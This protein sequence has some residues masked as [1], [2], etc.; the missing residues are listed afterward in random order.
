MTFFSLT[1]EE[2]AKRIE[3]TRAIVHELKTPITPVLAA[4]ELL[5]EEIKEAPL[6]G[7]VESIDRSASNLNR[8]I[9][10]LLDLARGELNMLRIYP[11]PI[12]PATLLQEI[13]NET[14]PMAV[15]NRQSF[16]LDMSQSLPSIQADRDRVR[17]VILN[18]LNNAFKLTPAGGQVT[19]SARQDDSNL[20]IAV[21]DTGPGM[22]VEEQER[23]FN[24]YYR[25][26]ND[27]QRLSGLGLGL[28]IASIFV[29]LHG[30][31]IWVKSAKGKGS[32]FSFSLPL[33]AAK[34]ENAETEPGGKP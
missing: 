2:I 13:T 15:K 4:V 32:T 10:E 3:Y 23:L 33:V 28:A 9:D 17:Q 16:V 18:L 30:G 14:M 6:R 22:S 19:L 27:R 7:L 25:V 1:Q 21:S 5:L 20:V 34:E 24:P 26:E 31:R 11:E 12:D 8:R 29:K